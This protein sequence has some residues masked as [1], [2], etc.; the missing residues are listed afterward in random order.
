MAD[1]STLVLTDFAGWAKLSV[2]EECAHLRR[3][4]ASASARPSAK[5]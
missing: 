5:A 3:W 2:P 4:Y 1:I